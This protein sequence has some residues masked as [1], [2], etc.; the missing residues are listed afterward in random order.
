MQTS[1]KL[2]QFPGS[3]N[4]RRVL[5][6]IEHLGVDVE[7]HL[8]DLAKGASRTPEYLAINPM[9]RTPTLVDGDF[10]LWESNAIIQYIA[11]RAR[12]EGNAKA[13]TLLP[14]DARGRADVTRWQAWQMSHLSPGAQVVVYENL[15]KRAFMGQDPDA[16]EVERGLKL[17][18]PNAK[19]LDSHLAGKTW[20]CGD[21]LTLADFTIAAVLMY[22]PMAGLSLAEYPNIRA[23]YSRVSELDAWVK[24]TP[25]MG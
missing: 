17:F 12:E 20:I 11:D 4:S 8:V 7:L 24:T 15:V 21:N 23:W 5:A 25:K 16:A 3:P 2:Y 18:T 10:V 22:A 13:A 19:F 14:G 9:G 6:V 1:M